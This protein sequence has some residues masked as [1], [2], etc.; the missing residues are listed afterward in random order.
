MRTS[1]PLF[2]G[3]GVGILVLDFYA[4]YNMSVR[5][6]PAHTVSFGWPASIVAALLLG[7]T[8]FKAHGGL[9]DIGAAAIM[10]AG[11]YNLLQ[12]DPTLSS[13]T[14]G[15]QEFGV[16]RFELPTHEDGTGVGGMQAEA[17]GFAL[18]NLAGYMKVIL[19]NQDSRQIFFFLLLNLSYMFV[20]MTY[21]IWTNSLGLISDCR[22]QGM[23]VWGVKR[24]RSVWWGLLIWR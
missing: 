19:E 17:G 5:S 8:I 4:S 1:L 6:V 21:G 9:F 3:L 20:Q 10:F 14:L 11:V 15:Y 7:P 23:L 2:L 18:V 13:D 16:N 22:Y 12:S 24:R